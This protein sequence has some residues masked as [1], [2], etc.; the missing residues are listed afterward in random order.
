MGTGTA[1]R[2]RGDGERDGV[3]TSKMAGGL[4]GSSKAESASTSSQDARVSARG[5]SSRDG[6]GEPVRLG[7]VGDGDRNPSTSRPAVPRTDLRKLIVDRGEKVRVRPG[8]ERG[9]EQPAAWSRAQ[10]NWWEWLHLHDRP[11]S[12]SRVMSPA[13]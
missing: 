2:G 7:N 9:W 12:R 11:D 13:A 1:T 8:D 4:E 3:V 5:R 10:P 6:R